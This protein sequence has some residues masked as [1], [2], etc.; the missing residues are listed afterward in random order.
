MDL[1]VW[2]V[3]MLLELIVALIIVA[4]FPTGQALP[5]RDAQGDFSDNGTW[6]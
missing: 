4:V 6:M 5:S 1:P 3:V 2:V